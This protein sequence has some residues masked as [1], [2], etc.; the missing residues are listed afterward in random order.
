MTTP[1]PR[2]ADEFDV[3]GLKRVRRHEV[4]R[5][6]RHES[7]HWIF[8]LLDDHWLRLYK[9]PLP[10]T[11]AGRQRF[12]AWAELEHAARVRTW[13]YDAD[14]E[15]GL[16]Y[17]VHDAIHAC[18][19]SEIALAPI[20]PGTGVPSLDAHQ[21]AE[22]FAEIMEAVA[23]GHQQGLLHGDLRPSN[24]F[25]SASGCRLGPPLLELMGERCSRGEPGLY[26]A[27]EILTRVPEL[28]FD[29]F[30]IGLAMYRVLT[31]G[32]IFDELPPPDKGSSST[33][34]LADL[35][36]RGEKLELLYP[37]RV[38]RPLRAVIARAT[39]LDP[40]ARFPDA[41][42]LRSALLEALDEAPIEVAAPEPEP[43]PTP[44]PPPAAEVVPRLPWSTSFRLLPTWVYAMT[45]VAFLGGTFLGALAFVPYLGRSGP[46]LAALQPVPATAAEEPV[47]PLASAAVPTPTAAEEVPVQELPPQ[48][49]GPE[50]GSDQFPVK[51]DPVAALAA[52]E[53]KREPELLA[54]LVRE[55][56]P[57]APPKLT[58]SQSSPGPRSLQAQLGETLRFEATPSERAEVRWFVNAAQ[59]EIG[60]ELRFSAD[61]AGNYEIRALALHEDGRLTPRLEW[62]IAVSE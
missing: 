9:D 39:E 18:A 50:A 35:A 43:E 45:A 53:P 28:S 4:Q 12:E 41:G 20:A 10:V 48:L 32:T 14:P 19:F 37:S 17:L 1:S 25:W 44:E 26:T 29:V 24:L 2:V 55:P 22:A 47:L 6:L 3:A 51:L 57:S 27:P 62:V 11:D 46:E 33:Q 52:A 13:E 61:S 40:A 21:I 34:L 30:G 54:P 23:S 60:P 5:L 16:P 15:T 42:A 59:S 7:D 56:A 31:G 36:E 38:D 8:E 58:W 49:F